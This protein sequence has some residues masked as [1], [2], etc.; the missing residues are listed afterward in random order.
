MRLSILLLLIFY[1]LWPISSPPQNDEVR[2]AITL[3]SVINYC[4]DDGAFSNI[5]ATEST[6]RKG[7]FWPSTGKDIWYKFTAVR[8]DISISVTGKAS[9]SGINTLLLPLVAIYTFDGTVLTEMI[10][11]MTTSN[12]LTTAYKG[13]LNVGSEY[14]IRISADNNQTGL[15]KLCIN[16]Y[17]PPSRPGQDCSTASILCSKETFTERNI[18]GP[19]DNNREIAGT[20]LT[21]ESN[22][23]WYKWT[24]DDNG[25]LTFTI[26]P[27]SNTD[28][29]DWVLYDLGPNGDCS[30]IVPANAIRCAAGNGINCS[31]R[32]YI[33]GLNMTSTDLSETSSCPPGQDG[34]LKYVDMI[35]G[36]NYALLIDNFSSGNNDFTVAFGGTA[37]F[38]GPATEILVTKNNQCNPNQS[39]TFLAGAINN[40]I[41]EW[42]FGENASIEQSTSPGP[43]EIT[44]STEGPKN[45]SLKAT[46]DVGCTVT[47]YY[48][49]FVSNTPEKPVII[50]SKT[51]LCVG[52]V[53]ALSTTALANGTYHWTGPD[54]FLSSDQNPEIIIT[55]PE[56]SGDYTLITKTG[57]CESEPTILTIPSIFK[58]PIAE[59][60]TDPI[61]QAKYGAPIAVN[62]INLSQEADSFLWNF[63]D[64]NT[65]TEK[66]PLHTYSIPGSYD[67]ILTAS[68]E[69]GCSNVVTQGKIVVLKD[70]SISI[71]GVFSPNGDGINDQFQVGIVNLKSYFI[72]I[73]NRWGI[74][75]F[76]NSNILS[77]WDG[78][79]RG[80]DLPVGVYYYVINARDITNKSIRL[81][82]SITLIR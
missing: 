41:L 7:S 33:T 82:G 4:S 5:D 32:Y 63:G 61:L 65:S 16:N 38:K 39:F 50:S 72:T 11:S 64:G 23:A 43:H 53:L 66:S 62:F 56:N 51:K 26:T 34:W 19:G 8:T 13:G 74:R 44:Y 71:P 68:N 67:I 54:N 1:S 69:N 31:P 20:C 80:E 10:G 29:I 40:R 9:G 46:N 24:A 21:I 27:S 18:S 36:H 15:F 12:N 14:Y 70:A 60:E 6:Y 79:L 57:D 42:N 48:N 52:D 59:F 81:S 35:Q 3:N 22:S 25:T 77:N 49:L 73:V 45:I 2:D 78:K 30:Q 76:Q 28:D 17:N 58:T 75:V 55:G 37:E 47:T